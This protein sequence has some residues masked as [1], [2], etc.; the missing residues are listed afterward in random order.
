MSSSN[1]GAQVWRVGRGVGVADRGEEVERLR[2]LLESTSEGLYSVDRE[3]RCTYINNAAAE[4]LKLPAEAALGKDMHA[5]IHHHHANGSPFPAE[6][7]PIY[8][9]ARTGQS[10]VAEGVFWR[11]DDTP[12]NCRYKASPIIQ[13]GRSVG[14]VVSFS[15]QTAHRRTQSEL[16][17][18]VTRLHY[19]LSAAGVGAWD[20]DLVK[21]TA[22]RS[23][24]HD[25]IFGYDELL[26][27]WSY[28][29]FLA[30]VHPE[31][32]QRVDQDFK[33]A[34][35]EETDW[36]FEARIH[37]ADGQLR[38]IWAT[39]TRHFFS[40]TQSAHMFG[41]VMD[42]TEKK[43]TQHALHDAKLRLQSALN[44]GEIGTWIW[45]VRADAVHADENLARMFAVADEDAR[46]GP[47]D[48]YVCAIHPEDLDRVMRLID[49]SMK[50]ACAYE[51][52]YRLRRP[53][54]SVRW[55]VAR[56]KP[57]YDA[58]GALTVFPGVVLDITERKAAEEAL[59]KQQ[60]W[61]EEVLNLAPTPIL[62]IEPGSARVLFAN[63]AVYELAGDAFQKAACAQE[64]PS[65][66][67]CTASDGQR[68]ALDQLPGV[69]LARGERLDGEELVW[70]TPHGPRSLIVYANTLPEMHG[71]PATGI[72]M[73]QDISDIK[74]MTDELRR[75]NLTKD[76]FLAIVSHELR[77]PLSAIL[78]WVNVLRIG[79]A[80]DDTLERAIA[81]IERNADAQ[82]R[83]I[84][85]I[86]D[87]SRIV[88]GQLRLE[89]QPMDLY[90]TLQA[91][92]DS[93]RPA[94]EAK[95]LTLQVEYE[96]VS[97]PVMGDSGRLQ[98]VIGNL[99]SNAIKFTDQGGRI[100][101]RLRRTEADFRLAVCDSGRGIAPEF[102][103][104]V[105]DRFQQQ[106]SSS[107]RPQGGL[108]L[109]LAI[110]KHLLDMLGGDI[111]AASEGIGKG[112][113]FTVTLPAILPWE[114]GNRQAGAE[115]TVA[116]VAHQEPGEQALS[117]LHVL[118]VD[119]SADA[120]EIIAPLLQFYG[121]RVSQASCVDAA[122]ELTRT[123]RPDVLLSDIEMPG[124]DGYVLI[125]SLRRDRDRAGELPAIALTAHAGPAA[126][127][128]ALRAGF[129]EHVAKPYDPIELVS[130]IARLAGR[131]DATG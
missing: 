90:T 112:A 43:R 27:D 110:A 81:A 89:P 96:T 40:E 125:Q 9:A 4:M 66:Y 75:A 126:R 44:A 52:D 11:S 19:A 99:L 105:F 114:G 49:E 82:T 64:Y 36:S 15:D 46:G 31:D 47:I 5:L 26:P 83:I 71:H 77:T 16:S 98:Q 10:Q 48:R 95:G 92:V 104:H 38:W 12:F 68:L 87:T 33:T 102:L 41:V 116:R 30:H 84:E 122:L 29:K 73:F 78:G 56:G 117:G 74:R 34:L 129:D 45:D 100:L 76:E 57:E 28:E 70:N 8:L 94:V 50:S 121:A 69:R 21:G 86:L 25:R 39:G 72:L 35:E 131:P 128:R 79:H 93:I 61:L 80:D 106:D 18:S 130:L 115:D 118:A 67:D 59:R 3:G 23:R 88:S 101:I 1:R 54:G 32:R 119:D 62:L 7:C 24:L 111:C 51:A 127:T 20:L 85:D 2:L 42:I 65:L 58:D 14:A 22:W 124:K 113:T 55:V 60:Q 120:L 53:D 123:G 97:A 108:G 37:R 17:A 103:P 91:A 13:D 107:T 63:R 109:G 6:E